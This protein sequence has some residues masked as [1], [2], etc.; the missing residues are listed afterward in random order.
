[1]YSL[2]H[3]YYNKTMKIDYTFHSHTYR[4]G[5]A[6]GDI[7]DYVLLA[8][9]NH[10]RIFG[11]SDHVFLP[12]VKEP[13]IRG[14][15]SLLDEYINAY[16]VSKNKHKDE[17]EM[18]LGFECEYADVFVDYYQNLLK[19]HKVEFLILGQH[20]GF[21]DNKQFIKYVKNHAEDEDEDLQRYTFDLIKGIKS[22]LFMYVAHPDLMFVSA[23]E[24]T[25]ELKE[26]TKKIIDT[27]IEYDIPLE[28]NIHG[29]IRKKKRKKYGVIGYPADYFWVEVS[30]SNAKVVYGGDF[31]ELYEVGDDTNEA[32]FIEFIR[33]HNLHLADIEEVYKNYRNKIK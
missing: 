26:L 19:E 33:A 25:P 10:Y 15:Y 30:K 16:N 6:E 27:A 29:F 24:V 18:H 20:N 2:F 8:I 31:H 1:M 9:K 7:E 32:K 3:F 22:G 12:G 11:V 4:C 5:H 23:K 21:D 13:R 17:I 28:V 14:D